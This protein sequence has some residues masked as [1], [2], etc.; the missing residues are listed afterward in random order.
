MLSICSEKSI[1]LLHCRL[2]LLKRKRYSIV[3]QLRE[4][5]AQLLKI[6]QNEAAFARVVP[7]LLF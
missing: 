6:G 2:S 4:D 5:I 3:R 1:K 7:L